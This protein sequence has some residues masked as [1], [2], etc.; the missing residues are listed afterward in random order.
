MNKSDQIESN[1]KRALKIICGSS[2]N[3]CEH[4]RILYNLPSLSERRETSCKQF[5]EKSALSSTIVV[6]IICCRR[7]E[8]LIQ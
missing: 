5:F 7:V 4:L 8:T 1:Q 2:I 6:Y 3:D